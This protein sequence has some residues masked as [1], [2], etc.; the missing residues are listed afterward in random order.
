MEFRLSWKRFRRL[1]SRFLPWGL[2]LRTAAPP[3]SRSRSRSPPLKGAPSRPRGS[4][5][6]RQR[7]PTGL[8]VKSC[9]AA[10]PDRS[11]SSHRHSCSSASA[12]GPVECGVRLAWPEAPHHPSLALQLLIP[13]R[14]P[15]G[16]LVRGVPEA[17]PKQGNAGG[18]STAVGCDAPPNGR[19]GARFSVKHPRPVQCGL[20]APTPLLTMTSTT[21]TKMRCYC[22]ATP[23]WRR[24]CCPACRRSS[25]SP[26][27]LPSTCLRRPHTARPRAGAASAYCSRVGSPASA[28]CFSVETIVKAPEA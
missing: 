25:R 22:S 24:C 21:L 18:T 27:S 5:L 23:S 10:P 15:L 20:A 26:A 28:A 7:G 6:L 9:P 3:R 1:W 17:P 2:A 12:T 19:C 8:S 13:P 4:I 16:R 14:L 11:V